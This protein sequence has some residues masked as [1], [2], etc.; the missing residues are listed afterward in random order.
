MS[1]EV[2]VCV[3]VCVRVCGCV[4]GV[5]AVAGERPFKCNQ[6]GASFTQKGNLQRHIKLHSGEKPFK[7][8]LLRLRLPSPG[9]PCP[10]TSEPIPVRAPSLWDLCVYVCLCVCACGG[11]GDVLEPGW[12]NVALSHC[13]AEPGWLNVALSHCRAEPGWLNVAL[14]HCRAEPGL[15]QCRPFPL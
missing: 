12:L 8:P 7:C 4:V 10:D 15:A 9:T 1:L 2:C 11:D 5:C 13:R 14:S 3:C 6:C